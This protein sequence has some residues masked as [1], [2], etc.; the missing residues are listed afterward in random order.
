M[1][2]LMNTTTRKV[3]LQKAKE[4]IAKHYSNVSSLT[5]GG[6]SV[7]PADLMGL[8]QKD[9]DAMAAAAKAHADLKVLIQAA[10]DAHVAVLPLLRWLKLYVL[11]QSGKGQASASTLEDFGFTVPK[12]AKPASPEVKASAVK[13]AA[14]TRKAR[15]T[16]GSK[17]KQA[18][19]G[20]TPATP[21]TP[22]A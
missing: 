21:A 15:H 9:L 8:I 12:T 20:E 18:I 22:K 1:P 19:T 11:L 4:G 10:H 7:S 3:T 13:K 16:L 2:N 6:V 14:A 17:Q 5:L